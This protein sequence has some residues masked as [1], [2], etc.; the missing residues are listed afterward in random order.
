MYPL[1][2]HQFPQQIAPI[3]KINISKHYGPASMAE[4]QYPLRSNSSL[5]L[6]DC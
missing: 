2:P 6:N 4:L 1:F 3:T 5:Y